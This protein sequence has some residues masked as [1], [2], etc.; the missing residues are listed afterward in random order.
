[1][2]QE[3]IIEAADAWSMRSWL[4]TISP[5]V[6]DLPLFQEY[7]IEA[8]DAWSMRS[9]L[10]AI[11]AC[12]RGANCPAAGDHHMAA[13]AAATPPALLPRITASA[14]GSVST[15]DRMFRLGLTE[16]Q[17]LQVSRRGFLH[18]GSSQRSNFAF[19]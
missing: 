16:S 2:F 3:C 8:A 6:C 13:S 10:T 1:L 19:M 15:A 18:T 14:A 4:T 7:I 11:H 12:M 5:P 9:W 17:S